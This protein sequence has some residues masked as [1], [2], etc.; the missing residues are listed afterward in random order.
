MEKPLTFS[1]IKDNEKCTALRLVFHSLHSK[2][3][4]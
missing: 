2:L 3:Y 1:F 4:L